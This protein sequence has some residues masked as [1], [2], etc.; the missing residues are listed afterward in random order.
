MSMRGSNPI[1]HD[2]IVGPATPAW[3]VPAASSPPSG[4]DELDELRSELQ[5]LRRQME[6]ES[7]SADERVQALFELLRRQNHTQAAIIERLQ[8]LDHQLP[9][10][11]VPPD[12]QPA[13]NPTI[14]VAIEG[15]PIVLRAVLN[16]KGVRRA[17]KVGY[18]PDC[19]KNIL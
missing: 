7:R 11:L 18:G 17:L 19:C 6:A 12:G 5:L 1:R 15:S 10:D 16:G 8:E 4:R 13:G 9:P 14:D 3:P 2:V